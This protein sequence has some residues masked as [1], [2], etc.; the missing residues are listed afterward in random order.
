ML[1]WEEISRLT[2]RQI[3]DIYYRKR[4]KDGIPLPFPKPEAPR[5]SGPLAEKE[6]EIELEKARLAFWQAQYDLKR[7]QAETEAKWAEAKD[8]VRERILKRHGQG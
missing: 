5:P 7:P 1:T 8:R 2:D 4:D 6:L 3:M